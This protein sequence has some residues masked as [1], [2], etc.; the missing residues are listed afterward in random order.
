MLLLDGIEVDAMQRHISRTT[1]EI[2]F[3][4]IS[5]MGVVADLSEFWDSLVIK[6]V[7][8]QPNNETL[9]LK[10]TPPQKKTL[11]LSREDQK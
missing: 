10:T 6:Q 1:D 2:I 5:C 11:R 8:C 3:C 4:N 9:P 7:L